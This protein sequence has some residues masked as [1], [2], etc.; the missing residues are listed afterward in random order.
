MHA[1]DVSLFWSIFRVAQNPWV[2]WF[3]IFCA[4]YMIYVVGVVFLIAL[5]R[6]RNRKRQAYMLL[7]GIAGEVIARGFIAEALYFIYH[8]ARPFVELSITALV[9]HA[10]TASFP[11][12]HV[13][14]SFF[15]AF[16]LFLYNKK[17]GWTATILAI[18]IAWGRVAVGVHWPTDVI[19]GALIAGLVFWGMIKWFPFHKEEEKTLLPEISE[20]V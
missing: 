8:R 12:G 15:L 20:L 13:T 10:P 16:T 18:L 19:G 9:H 17:W 1:F 4:Q 11:S 5:A 7:V 6:E 2:S 14:F 3:A